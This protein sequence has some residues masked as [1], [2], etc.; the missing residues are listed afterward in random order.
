VISRPSADSFTLCHPKAK[1]IA[2]R[3]FVGI[4]TVTKSANKFV[5][6]EKRE[7]ERGGANMASS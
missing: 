6:E 4:T 5:P 7:R 2:D 3:S 1:I